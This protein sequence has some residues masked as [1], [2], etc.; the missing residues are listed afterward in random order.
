[1]AFGFM[2]APNN[3]RPVNIALK[4][5]NHHNFTDARMETRAI[6]LAGPRSQH[7]HPGGIGVI[8][9]GARAAVMAM[10]IRAG[11]HSGL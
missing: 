4:E 10:I 1:M 9:E 8:V 7:I 6:A 5:V 11:K 3:K 2:N